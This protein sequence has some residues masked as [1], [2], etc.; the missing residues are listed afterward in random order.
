MGLI[1]ATLTSWYLG[2]DHGIRD[3]HLAT[4]AV[5]VVAFMKVRFVGLYFMELRDAPSL[6]KG[7][8]EAHCAVVCSVLVAVYLIAPLAPQ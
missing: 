4:V 6:L 7:I 2:S 8:F 5:M 1:V 3:H